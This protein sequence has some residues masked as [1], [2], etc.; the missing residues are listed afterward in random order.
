MR[1]FRRAVL[2]VLLTTATALGG[3]GL[4]PGAAAATAAIEWRTWGS[5]LQ[6]D[7][8]VD[9]CTTDGMY[10]DAGQTVTAQVLVGGNWVDKASVTTPHEWYA[11][12]SFAV[13]DL[14]PAP[15]AWSV[16][17]LTRANPSAPLLEARSTLSF[18]A[19]PSSVQ[20]PGEEFYFHTGARTKTVRVQ[21]S[22]ANGQQV[23]L[24]RRA[25]SRWV[26][27]GRATVP[28]L[29]ESVALDV[30]VPTRAGNAT[31]RLVNRATTWST[32]SVS[33][34][35]LVHQTDSRRYSGYIAEARRHIARYCPK[36]PI[37]VDIP[38]VEGSGTGT[39]GL[40]W[41]SWY[42]DQASGGWLRT[43]L[44]QRSGLRGKELEHTALHECAHIVQYR[45]GVEDKYYLERD[46]AWRLWP[47]VGHEGQADCM[48][49]HFSRVERMYYVPRGCSPRQMDSSRR[50]WR[51]YGPKYQAAFYRWG[52][53]G[54]A[55]AGT[56]P[57]DGPVSTVVSS[58]DH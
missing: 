18:V 36:T 48:A 2:G 27:V 35:F 50:M 47:R 29:D 44:A 49:H 16:R 17:A 26:T 45:A 5:T 30:R 57:H 21:V 40:A 32:R 12:V 19:D 13:R 24:Q 8:P 33:P 7:A 25:G 51:T 10:F 14:V 22:P 31:Y 11:C 54:T 9:V 23:E 28:R 42:G 1:P 43:A 6:P 53:S 4:A 20:P 34:R 58:H 38:E 55:A 39:I 46:R 41:G 52:P 3:V 15:G 37:Y 56:V